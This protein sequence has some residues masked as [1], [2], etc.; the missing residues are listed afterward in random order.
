MGTPNVTVDR[1]CGWVSC[2]LCMFICVVIS[3]DVV[4]R[5]HPL[6]SINKMNR[7]KKKNYIAKP[8]LFFDIYD[9][10]SY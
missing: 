2:G 9:F 4:R 6:N 1:N 5:P 7:K 3:I 8:V 10:V